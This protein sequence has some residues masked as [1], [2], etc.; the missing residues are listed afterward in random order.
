VTQEISAP[1]SAAPGIER[2]FVTVG[3]DY[4]RF[5]RMVWWLD[6]WLATGPKVE[7]AIVQRGTSV[8]S[9]HVKSVDYLQRTQLVEEFQE[10]T[11]VVCHGG[12]H[13]GG[14]Q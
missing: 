13:T 9:E 8:K 6:E 2:L 14:S 3:T 11:A 7:A 4:H 12:P 1:L 5:D 10:A